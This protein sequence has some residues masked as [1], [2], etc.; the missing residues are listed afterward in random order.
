[1]PTDAL[2]PEERLELRLYNRMELLFAHTAEAMLVTDGIGN[3]IAANPPLLRLLKLP[4]EVLRATPVGTFLEGGARENL[5][6]RHQRMEHGFTSGETTLKLEG[7]LVPVRYWTIEVGIGSGERRAYIGVTPNDESL[8]NARM[9]QVLRA[10][11]DD[12]PDG[13]LVI[14]RAGWT[15]YANDRHLELWELDRT[16]LKLP[17][18]ERAT[19]RR[20]RLFDATSFD[21]MSEEI[22]ADPEIETSCEAQLRG[23]TIVEV[24]SMPLFSED[25]NLIGRSYTTRDITADRQAEAVLRESEERYR[26]LVATLPVGVVMQYADG[27]IGAANAAAQRIL[28]LSEDQL[29][30]LTS[31]DPRWQAIDENGAEFPPERHPAVVTLSTGE[32]CRD[33]RMGVHHASGSL[34]WLNVNSE[35]LRDDSGAISGVVITFQDVTEQRHAEAAI[36]RARTADAYQSLA[37]GVAHKIN[38]SLSTIL[39]NAYLAGLPKGLPIDTTESLQEIVHA[40]SGATAT[41]RDLLALSGRE[42]HARASLNL[43]DAVVATLETFELAARANIT[44]ELDS[45]LPPLLADATAI[46][47]AVAS[48]IRNGLE[49]GGPVV[50]RTERIAFVPGSDGFYSP[51]RP[52]AGNYLAIIVRDHGNGLP[53]EVK[54]RLF[55]PFVTTKFAGRGLGLAA[56]SGIMSMHHGFVELV[57]TPDGCTATLL[58]PAP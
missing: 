33:V 19:K 17:L 58:F 50:V 5:Q 29:L 24:R 56:A 41:V 51:S 13:K 27:T 4:L 37:S 40:A 16:D 23:G 12:S 32:P 3:V 54:P 9:A 45:A 49:A 14:N 48:I 7:R 46:R 44:I 2:T 38:N 15:I 10:H 57:S 25:G 11:F 43:S 18:D 8:D 6:I 47:Q 35:P 1:M 31:F 53:E 36:S 20:S 42:R 26:T 22:S 55:E 34:R 21:R 30:G 28:G 39:G 52:A